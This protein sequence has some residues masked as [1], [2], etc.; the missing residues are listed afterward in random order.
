M[1]EI[2]TLTAQGV[3]EVTLL[4]QNVNAYRGKFG[5]AMTGTDDKADL[6]AAFQAQVGPWLSE[7]RVRPV[8]D[9]ALSLPDAEAARRGM[10]E[11][12]A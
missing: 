12:A 6:A 10:S 4:G 8:I 11:S 1:T 5:G 9:A 2:A 3:H 7:G